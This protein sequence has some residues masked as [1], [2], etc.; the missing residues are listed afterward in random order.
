MKNLYYFELD[1]DGL[2]KLTGSFTATFEEV[3]TLYQHLFRFTTV[4]SKHGYLEGEIKKSNIALISKNPEFV[5]EW[6]KVTGGSVGVNPFDC[7]VPT[8][9]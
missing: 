7:I 1:T 2:G 4:L 9:E 6:E 8:G 5:A 3:E